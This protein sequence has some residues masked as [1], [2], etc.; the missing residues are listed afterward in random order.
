MEAWIISVYLSEDVADERRAQIPTGVTGFL[1]QGHSKGVGYYFRV[2][3]DAD[4]YPSAVALVRDAATRVLEPGDIARIIDSDHVM[5][6]RQAL[7]WVIGSRLQIRRWEIVLARYLKS[8]LWTSSIGASSDVW[9]AQTE[10]HLALVATNNFVRAVENTRGRITAAADEL[11]TD[12]RLLRDL[13]EHWNEQW[14]AFYDRS[15]P[16]P[17]ARSGKSFAS[18]HPGG[19]PYWWLGWDSQTGP[20]L[21]PGL[22]V[23]DILSELDR[24][25]SAVLESSPQLIEYLA[26]IDDSPWIS[27]PK[28]GRWWP[29]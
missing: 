3:V 14:P 2:G 25:Q 19:D 28:A 15:N 27:D 20:T 4:D 6:D 8:T 18:R 24:V 21:G 10:W 5:Q 17:L 9:Q 13:Q 12:I 26:P 7:L 16:G 22:R 23:E 11:A 29:K 1:G